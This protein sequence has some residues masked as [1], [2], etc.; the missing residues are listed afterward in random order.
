MGRD[1][2][3]ET[4]KVLFFSRSSQKEIAIQ[5][6]DPADGSLGTWPP[7]FFDQMSLNL[8]ILTEVPGEML[9]RNKSGPEFCLDG[10]LFD[11][12]LPATCDEWPDASST[13]G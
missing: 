5:E 11:A 6:R 4:C 1:P 13:H 3:A 7:G 2:F 8:R 12:E 9:G 10:G